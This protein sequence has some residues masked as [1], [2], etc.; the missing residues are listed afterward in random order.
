MIIGEQH[1]ELYSMS[2]N[3]LKWKRIDYI[4][5][6]ICVCVCVCVS[7]PHCCTPET[8]ATL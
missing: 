7:E 6:C 5:T 3:N 8:D 2:C 1:K 4:Y